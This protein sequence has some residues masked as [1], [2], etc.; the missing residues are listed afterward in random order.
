ME[1]EIP[2]TFLGC[3]PLPIAQMVFYTLWW[4]EHHPTL[5]VVLTHHLHPVCG[6]EASDGPCHLVLARCSL[7]SLQQ[8]GPDSS[9]PLISMYT[10]QERLVGNSVLLINVC[11]PLTAWV[12]I[13]VEPEKLL[14]T[15]QGTSSLPQEDASHSQGE[16]LV[17]FLFSFLWPVP[18]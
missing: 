7:L 18:T 15:L 11:W 17:L 4:L 5:P 14:T 1:L 8:N 16:R 2:P 3:K 13:K 9:L 12:K 6:M 10:L